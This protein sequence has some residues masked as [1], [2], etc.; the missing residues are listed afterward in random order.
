MPVLRMIYR[1]SSLQNQILQKMNSSWRVHFF[2]LVQQSYVLLW[3]ISSFTNISRHQELKRMSMIG[4]VPHGRDLTFNPCSGLRFSSH[5]PQCWDK[6]LS[7]FSW[8]R[9]TIWSS[10]SLAYS[11]FHLLSIILRGI[12]RSNQRSTLMI[13]YWA[14]VSS[15]LRSFPFCLYK[16]HNAS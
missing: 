13:S 10:E 9:F 14:H 15:N 5:R 8:S 12:V 7:R 4:T 16:V 1:T 3:S 11:P 2:Y 6:A